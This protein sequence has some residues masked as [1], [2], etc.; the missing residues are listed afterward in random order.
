MTKS[1]QTPAAWYLLF[2]LM[3]FQGI[4]GLFGGAALVW[5]PSGSLLSLPFSFL[6]GTPF[7]DYLL[8][9]IILF[10]VLG[11]FP[12][13]VLFG[14]WHRHTWSWLCTLLV[15]IALIVWIMVE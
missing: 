7:S 14:L 11:I 9:G 13:V 8:P 5:D 12:L 3:M 15:S 10:T 4:S 2:S 6:D 1:I